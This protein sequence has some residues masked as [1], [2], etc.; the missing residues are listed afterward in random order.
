VIRLA[1]EPAIFLE[2]FPKT[3][4]DVFLE[5]VQAD[6]STRV[7]GINA[8]SLALALAGIPM[9]DLVCACSVG[10]VDGTLVVDLNGKEDN[11][12]EADVAF[13]LMPSK[14]K[15]TLLQMDGLLSKEELKK[16][17]GM[18]K[19][20]CKKIYELQKKALR[21]KYKVRE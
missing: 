21:E 4:I 15:I 13:A 6:G 5:V 10:K 12:G 7:T 11:F 8:A 14:N 18:A 9:R 1:L 3:A 19:E 17:I 16:L 2:D 20:A